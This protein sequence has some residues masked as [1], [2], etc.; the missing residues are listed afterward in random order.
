[1]TGNRK[2]LWISFIVSIVLVLIGGGAY[3]TLR[4]QPC[5]QQIPPEVTIISPETPAMETTGD[6]FYIQT[7]AQ[8]SAG[9]HQVHLSVGGLPYRYMTLCET[10][11]L[12]MY[13]T[14]MVLQSG[15]N[16]S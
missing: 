10:W 2:R 13:S 11:N 16:K 15:G 9:I 4:Y 1:M 8:A 14:R 5:T 3:F 12:S 7:F 6:F